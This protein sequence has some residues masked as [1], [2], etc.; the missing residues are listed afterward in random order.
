M[1]L[2]ACYDDPGPCVGCSW[3]LRADMMYDRQ[4]FRILHLYG[5]VGT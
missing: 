4:G 3:L 2:C 1:R 5:V